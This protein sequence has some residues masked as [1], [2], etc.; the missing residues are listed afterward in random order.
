VRKVG[1]RIATALSA[2]VW[3]RPGVGRPHPP[4]GVMRVETRRIRAVAEE[5][6]TQPGVEQGSRADVDYGDREGKL[7]PGRLVAWIFRVEDE[8]DRIKW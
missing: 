6:R 8:G 1:G 5:L 2:G 7:R 4:P 3:R